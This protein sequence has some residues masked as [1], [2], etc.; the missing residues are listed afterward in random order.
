MADDILDGMKA[1][2]SKRRK[3]A[4]A[5]RNE[6]LMTYAVTASANKSHYKKRILKIMGKYKI[7]VSA[8]LQK[9]LDKDD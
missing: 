4:A 9:V 3:E 1:R 5:K 8:E 2:E 6:I 7:K